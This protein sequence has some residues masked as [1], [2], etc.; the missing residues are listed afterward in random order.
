MKIE[1]GGRAERRK[2]ERENRD[3][4]VKKKKTIAIIILINSSIN[5]NE[6]KRLNDEVDTVRR[7]GRRKGGERRGM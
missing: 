5:I 1:G 7:A 4:E 3:E 6:D 2:E